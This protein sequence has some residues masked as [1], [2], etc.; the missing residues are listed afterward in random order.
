MPSKSDI[1]FVTGNKA[2]G[3]AITKHGGFEYFRKFL[4]LDPKESCTLTGDKNEYYIMEVL[5][6]K[7]YEVEK[8]KP[9][10]PYDI[11]VN[12][13]VKIDV[14]SSNPFPSKVYKMNEC[15]FA[16][17][18]YQPKCDIFIFVTLINNKKDVYI[19]PSHFIK[20]SQLSIGE[21]SKYDCYLNKYE[22]IDKYIEL[23]NKIA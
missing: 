20:Q 15:V 5:K 10:H 4:G 2:L 6:N 17:N 12:G 9:R 16:I 1:E 7:G 8:T 3:N 23:F 11:L 21:T 22:Y 14:K 19:I 13:I 18:N